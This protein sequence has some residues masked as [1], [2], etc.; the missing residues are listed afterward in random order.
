M[1]TDNPNNAL[2]G[3]VKNLSGVLLLCRANTC[4]VPGLFFFASGVVSEG[5]SVFYCLELSAK[6]HEKKL[7]MVM[8]WGW[9]REDAM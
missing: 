2:P 9:S 4:L 6:E 3:I 8:L 1:T 7:L 5:A